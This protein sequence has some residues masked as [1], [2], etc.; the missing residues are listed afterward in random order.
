MIAEGHTLEEVL[1]A[2]LTAEYD[3]QWG[4]EAAW[5]ASDLLPIVYNEYSGR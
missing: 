3:A 5:N 1:A 4:Q 2:D